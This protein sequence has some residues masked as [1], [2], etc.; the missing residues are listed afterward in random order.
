MLRRVAGNYVTSY[1]VTICVLLLLSLA[2]TTLFG[3][4][5]RMGGGRP[6]FDDEGNPLV[7]PADANQ[8]TEYV[9]ARLQYPSLGGNSYWNMRGSWATDYPKA[10][11]QFVMGVRRLSRLNVRSVEEVVDLDSD[12]IFDYPWIYA[13]E[14]GH[15]N[16]TDAQCRKLREYLLRGG[17]MM[18]DD[19]HGTVEW[20][21]FLR[22]MRRVFPD[23]AIVDLKDADPVFHVLYDLDQRFQV[24]GVQVLYTGR[25]A[26]YDGT[27]GVWR[28]IFDDDGRLMVAITHNMDLGDAWEHADMP[29]YPERYSSLAYRV[30]IN[31]II[32]AM[33]H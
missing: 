18:T 4:Q 21:V 16:L 28:G 23:R 14:T 19:F 11:R 13:T 9:F 22:S 5:R 10:D 29:E 8:K 33:T 15:W 2:G 32:Y 20:E 12:K 31:Y 30:G 6:Q 17:F 1:R 7:E 24:P 25:V 27:E 26:E 3:L